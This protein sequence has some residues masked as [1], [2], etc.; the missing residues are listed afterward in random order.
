M[1]TAEKTIHERTLDVVRAELAAAQAE[2]WSLVEEVREVAEAAEQAVE[3]G[4]VKAIK[5]VAV[6]RAEL[7]LLLAAAVRRRARLGLEVAELELAEVEAG[8]AAATKAVMPLREAERRAREAREEA[9]AV[10]GDFQAQGYGARENLSRA[11]A[12][13]ETVNAIDLDELAKGARNV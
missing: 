6:R 1:S 9:E 3:S 11:R 13:L 10:V 4:D 5:E 8:R 12:A 2:E 7:P